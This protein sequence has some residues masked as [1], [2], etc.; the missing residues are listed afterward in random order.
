MAAEA[1]AHSVGKDLYKIDLTTVVSKYI[2]ETEQKLEQVFLAAEATQAVL[3]FDEADSLLGKRSEVKDAHDR[4]ANLEVS[5]LL[6]RMERYDGLIILAT[7]LPGNLDSAFVRR[8]AAI[9]HFQQPTANERRRLWRKAW[10]ANERGVITVPLASE[11]RMAVDHDYL[12]ERFDFTGGNIS[13]VV[14]ASAFAAAERHWFRFVTM[15]DVL[16]GVRREFQK[17]GQLM[18]DEELGLHQFMPPPSRPPGGHGNVNA[19]G[20]HA[21]VYAGASDAA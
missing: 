2:G 3:F 4:Y 5:Y 10:P 1:I 9:V 12:A 15:W 11:P 7:N 21:G 14:F 16:Q 8:M 20:W 13:N 18:T 17:L 19:N 6:Q